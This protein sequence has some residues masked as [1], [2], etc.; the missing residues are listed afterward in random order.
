MRQSNTLDMAQNVKLISYLDIPGGG[1]IVVENCLAFIGHMEPPYGTSIVDVSNTRNPKILSQVSPPSGYSHTHKVRV[2]GDLMFTNVER[3]KRHFYRKGELIGE[4]EKKFIAQNDRPP[5][6]VELSH[7]LGISSED[8]PE[9]REG[10]ARGY[11][12]GGF[13]IYDISD[14]ESPKLINHHITGGVGVHRFDVDDNYAYI[15]TEMD[16]FVGNI[17]VI[18]DI[19]DPYNIKE[20]SRWWMPGQNVADGEK[21]H[22]QGQ[23]NRLHHALRDGNRL[24]ASCWHAGAWI[25]DIHDI[26]SPETLGSFDYHPP[27]IEPTHTFFRIPNVVDGKE[28]A[29]IADEQHGKVAG[30]PPAFMWIVDVTDPKDI[31]ALSTF[32]VSELDSPYSSSNG[33]FGLHQIAEKVHGTL[34]YAAWFSAGLRII[35][36]ADPARPKE[37]GSFVPKEIYPGYVP[38]SNDVD[39][40]DNGTIYLLD[41]NNGV[42][43]LEYKP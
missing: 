3:H 29:I 30:Q 28:I 4:C 2:V 41:R 26:E 20:I 6:E 32:H 33:R 1:Q 18:Y 11:D 38:Q 37:A 8:L 27:F 31:K 16:G 14:P 7:M 5:S 13:C 39:I 40:D 43:I 35:D 23:K 12:E 42:H 17:L 19:K 25:I 24:W 15:S 10:L 22:W 21:P 36:I 34:I 9:L